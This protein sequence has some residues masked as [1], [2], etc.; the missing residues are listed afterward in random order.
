MQLPAFGFAWDADFLPVDQPAAVTFP[1]HG[2]AFLKVGVIALMG[3]LMQLIPVLLAIFTMLL[4]RFLARP[5]LA[6][7]HYSA[8]ILGNPIKGCQSRWKGNPGPFALAT[9]L[10]IRITDRAI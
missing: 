10:R 5:L 3:L 9:D 6:G 2:P 7:N 8:L 1:A 4:N